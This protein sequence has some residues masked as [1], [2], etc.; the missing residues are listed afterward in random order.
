VHEHGLLYAIGSTQ[1]E[2]ICQSV[3]FY[4]AATAPLPLGRMYTLG[5]KLSIGRAHSAALIPE[6]LGLIEAGRL[7]PEMVTTTVVDW[8]DAATAYL[9]ETIKLVVR[10]DS[11]IAS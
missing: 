10:R 9:D 11:L 4:P 5:V 2:G 6:V 8:D 1:P 3:S 7:H